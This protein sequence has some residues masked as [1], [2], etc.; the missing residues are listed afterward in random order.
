MSQVQLI[1]DLDLEFIAELDIKLKDSRF[2]AEIESSDLK[3]Y[4]LNGSIAADF[5][6]KLKIFNTEIDNESILIEINRRAIRLQHL[7]AFIEFSDGNRFMEIIEF[8]TRDADRL[9][10]LQEICYDQLLIEVQ[11]FAR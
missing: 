7:P 4:V 8:Q 2:E 5:A 1:A 9:E 11:I 10:E 6:V 3:I